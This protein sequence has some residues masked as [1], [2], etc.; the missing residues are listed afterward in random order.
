MTKVTWSVLFILVGGIAGA[1]CGPEQESDETSVSVARSE[2]I[3]G[4]GSG[5]SDISTTSTDWTTTAGQAETAGDSVNDFVY[6]AYN[7]ED[8][9]TAHT[10]YITTGTQDP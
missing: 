2:L 3:S 1:G 7:A 8:T 10:Q 4:S 6:V 5:V 9:N